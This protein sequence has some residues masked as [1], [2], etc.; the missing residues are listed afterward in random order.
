[1]LRV[2]EV[3]ANF[4]ADLV[5]LAEYELSQAGVLHERL[6]EAYPYRAMAPYST[7]V[8]LFSRYPILAQRVIPSP[9]LRSPILRVVVDVEGVAVTVYVVHLVSP[10]VIGLPW[11]YDDTA[12]DRELA[13][14]DDLLAEERGPLLM[15]C[16]CNF[17]D[18]SDAYRVVAARLTDAY[19]EAGQGMGFTFPSQR[20]LI[21]LLVRLDYLWHSAHFTALEARTLDDSGTS[22]HRPVIARLALVS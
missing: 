8:A 7:D 1:M 15:L 6:A 9:L 12:R 17:T 13:L 14:V 4:E 19:R 5:A 2:A 18:Q 16:D 21:P 11:N 20:R 3:T 10:D 22:D